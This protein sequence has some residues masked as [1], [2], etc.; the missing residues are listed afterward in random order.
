MD[1]DQAVF[2]LELETIPS[3]L[4]N[5]ARIELNKAPTPSVM[6]QSKV[7][8]QYSKK[9]SYISAVEVFGPL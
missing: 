2:E 1:P 4:G 7:N 5:Q 8:H 6:Q 9:K 3:D